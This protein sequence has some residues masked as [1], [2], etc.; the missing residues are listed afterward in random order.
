MH[1]C[2]FNEPKGIMN[3]H[4]IPRTVYHYRTIAFSIPLGQPMRHI[5]SA[6]IGPVANGQWDQLRLASIGICFSRQLLMDGGIRSRGSMR[7]LAWR[8]K[9]SEINKLIYPSGLG[10][11]L[12]SGQFFTK[13]W[14]NF[15][16]LLIPA[17]FSSTLFLNSFNLQ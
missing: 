1:Y 13:Q 8:L 9:L 12:Q 2:P 11:S 3:H 4:T 15:F 5:V 16:K 7:K 6:L 10:L 17:A 14:L